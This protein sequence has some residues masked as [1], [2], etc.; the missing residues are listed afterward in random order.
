MIY[1]NF[2]K[3]K[4]KCQFCASDSKYDQLRYPFEYVKQEIEKIGYKLLSTHYSNNKQ[5]LDIRCDKNHTINMNF[6][7]FL[8]EQRCAE[9]HGLAKKTIEFV[10]EEFTKRGY[11]L[12][13][14]EYINSSGKLDY[15]CNKGHKRQISWTSF[16]NG[17]GCAKCAELCKYSYDEIKQAF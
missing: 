2:K 4:Y 5:I 16:Q 17:H 12:I 1:V 13:S 8:Q 6:N 9:C 15:I 11:I 10:I 7:N 3:S 14:T